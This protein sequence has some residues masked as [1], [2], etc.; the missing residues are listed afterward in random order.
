MGEWMDGVV[1][2]MAHRRSMC[3]CMWQMSFFACTW[4]PHF[5]LRQQHDSGP[6]VTAQQ[7]LVLEHP[8]GH[9]QI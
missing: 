5:V 8:Q 1:C 7:A 6:L 4:L 2:T 3:M 9:A